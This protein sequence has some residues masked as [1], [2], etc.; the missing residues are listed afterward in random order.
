MESGLTEDELLADYVSK[1][2]EAD[3]A[4]QDAA[5]LGDRCRDYYDGNQLT[6]AERGELKKRKQPPVVINRVRRKVDWL[7]G[8]EMQSR[9]DPKAFPRTPKHEAGA[10]AVTDAIRYVCDS[11]DLDR[12]R[13][14]AWDNI[15]VEGIGAIE[16]VHEVR[17]GQPEPDVAINWYS[18]DRVFHDPHSRMP[19]FSDATFLGAVVWQD[20]DQL[21]RQF[22]GEENAAKIDASIAAGSNLTGNFDDIPKW[23]VWSDKKRKRVRLVL[24]HCLRDGVW[25]WAKLVKG[26]IL[27]SGESPYIDEFGQSVCPLLLQSAYI[28]RE[29]GRYGVVKDMLDP[30][31]EI[32]KRRSKLLHQLNSRQT[33]GIKGAVS[34]A[35]LKAEMA[36][37]D[38]HVEIDADIASA[39]AEMGMKPF[40]IIQNADQTSGQ[41]NLLQEAKNEIDM[42]GANSGL[43]GKESGQQSGRAIMAKQ[44]GG[45]IEIAP[46][47]DGLSGFTRRIYRHIW[48]RIRQFWRAEKWVRVTDSDKNSRFVGLNRT[49]TLRERLSGMPEEQVVAVARQMGLM[50]NDPRLEMMVEIENDIE[51]MDV[52]ILIEEVPDMVTLEAETFEQIVN[53][54]TSM[55]GSVPPEIL[56][57]LAPGLK[58]D[59]KE[60]IL[61]HLK[62]K[63]SATAQSGQAQQQAQMQMMQVDAAKKQAET[64]K[65]LSLAQKTTVEAQRLALG[66]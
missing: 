41:F 2:E 20:A 51:Q 61:E 18:Y 60:K 1:F 53:I 48:M 66:Y 62:G 21:K 22:R 35:T 49:V 54:A 39:A 33:V 47:T 8:L 31:D 43:A 57:E 13:S 58:R 50:P 37:P 44:Q 24:M 45:L 29:G 7:R 52:D 59:V 56:V 14:A 17:P 32:N 26:G 5:A 63:E 30:Q 36:K 40:D 9:T 38:G 55:P 28:D 27:D 46:L 6:E 65:T 10:N 16:V 15:L 34:V 25:H 4:R 12:K 64:Q 42:M 19:D 23:K 11:T 3:E